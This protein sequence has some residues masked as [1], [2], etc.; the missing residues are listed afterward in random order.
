MDEVDLFRALSCS[1]SNK[2]TLTQGW[3]GEGVGGVIS[4]ERACTLPKPKVVDYML[5][6]VDFMS[7]LF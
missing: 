7:A 1:V 4:L 3:G 6:V 2:L 5:L